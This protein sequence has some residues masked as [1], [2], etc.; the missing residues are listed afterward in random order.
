MKKIATHVTVR[1]DKAIEIIEKGL[2]VKEYELNSSCFSSTGQFG[3]GLEEHIDLGLKYDPSVGIY[4]MH[5]VIV[6]K[7]AGYRVTKRKRAQRKIAKR[8]RVTKND[9]IEWYKKK[10]DG[11]VN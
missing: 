3:F 1:G 4:G 9:S 5:F 8:H 11:I 10:F 2:K 6:L 7:R